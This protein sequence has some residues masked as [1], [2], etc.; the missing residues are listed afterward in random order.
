MKTSTLETLIDKDKI[1]DVLHN[2][3]N[4]LDACNW[5]QVAALFTKPFHLQ[6]TLIDVD[7]DRE[8]QPE[9]YL[10]LA[11]QRVLPGFDFTAHLCKN[12]TIT[13]D[14]TEAYLKTKLLDSCHHIKADGSAIR[15]D[16]LS[17]SDGT[18]Y[19]TLHISWEGWLTRQEDGR[20]LI[21]KVR[22]SESAVE[23]NIT[24]FDKAMARASGD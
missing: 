12:T 15:T 11:P 4:G 5:E 14:G 16:Q 23:G 1:N 24:V 7:I 18:S 9:E 6:A 13:L 21:R 8:V 2:Y 17:A 19:C 22:M 20:W 10:S 3:M